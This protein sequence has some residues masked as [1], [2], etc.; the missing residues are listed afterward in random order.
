MNTELTPYLMVRTPDGFFRLVVLTAEA[1][2]KSQAYVAFHQAVEE[3]TGQ[4]SYT[5]LGVCLIY[6]L[7]EGLDKGR[8]GK[9]SIDVAQAL[10]NHAGLMAMGMGL[11]YSHCTVAFYG[12]AFSAKVAAPSRMYRPDGACGGAA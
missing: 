6:E 8:V 1:Q 12:K 9:A 2:G 4:E 7:V 10:V 5:D 3:T 11:K